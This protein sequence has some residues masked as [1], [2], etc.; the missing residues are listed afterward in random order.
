MQEKKNEKLFLYGKWIL[1]AGFF[2]AALLLCSRISYSDGDDAYFY[3]MAHSMPFLEY[4]KMRY[5]GWEGRMTSEA[6]TY[7]AFYF[8][9]TFWMFANA[10]VFTLLPAGLLCILKKMSGGLTRRKE[11][12]LTLAMMLATLSLGIEVIGYGAFWITGSTFYLWSIVAGIWA[13]VPFVELVYG[14]PKENGERIGEGLTGGKTVEE[15]PWRLFFYALPCGFIAA[16]GQEQIAAVVI[17][18]GFLAVC[19]DFYRRRKIS[20]LHLTEVVMMIV[21]LALLFVSP[22]TDA[23]S[24][25]EIETWMPQYGTM[26]LGNHIFITLQWMLA[27]FANEGK[28]LFVLIWLLSLVVMLLRRRSQGS[29]AKITESGRKV[30]DVASESGKNP[31][32]SGIAPWIC[33]GS[34]FVIAALLPYAGITIFSDMGTGVTDITVC[35]TEVAT[36][37]TVSIQNWLAMAWWLAAL[38]FTI[39]LLWHIEEKL[40]DKVV[41]ALMILAACATEAIMFFSPTMYASGARVYFMAQILLWLLVGRLCTKVLHDRKE[42][43][44]VV[45]IAAAGILNV[46][47]GVT[48]VL[49]YLG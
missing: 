26:S 34:A 14:S 43:P 39:V 10:A 29:Q 46:V 40:R 16:M 5:I 7:I 4:L 42:L 6:M 15:K 41:A 47:N 23:R 49:S 27:S 30:G 37:S 44:I 45:L 11:F 36:P 28:M 8:G 13:A 19:Y 24:Q 1:C 25:S 31:R 9:K 38:G 22:G 20:W 21:S 17:A 48:V 3:S 35:V 32:K 12:F 2:L 33:L 18:F